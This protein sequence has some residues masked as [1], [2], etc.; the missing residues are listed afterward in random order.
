MRDWKAEYQNQKKRGETKDQ[1]ERQKARRQ[2]DR[3]GIDRTGKHIDHKVAIK[4]GGRTSKGNLR[5]RDP[6]QNMADNRKKR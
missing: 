4:D 1:L 6:G 5:L 3:E 2:Y